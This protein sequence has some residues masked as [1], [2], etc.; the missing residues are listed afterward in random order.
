[1]GTCGALASPSWTCQSNPDSAYVDFGSLVHCKDL[2]SAH[3]GSRRLSHFQ[4]QIHDNGEYD[5]YDY[6]GDND[7]ALFASNCQPL[8]PR[9]CCGCCCIRSSDALDESTTTLIFSSPA[10]YHFWTWILLALLPLSTLLGTCTVYYS[11]DPVLS[12]D[13][14]RRALI[15][16]WVATLAILVAYVVCLP[17]RYEVHSDATLV[18]ITRLAAF[19][20]DQLVAASIDPPLIDICSYGF[21]NQ[22]RL[23][24]DVATNFENRILIRRGGGGW[25]MVVSPWNAP[26]LVAAVEQVA[27]PEPPGDEFRECEESAAASTQL[28][29]LHLV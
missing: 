28:P 1:M 20:F 7:D 11:L 19:Q 12:S 13:Q 15:G 18:V 3:A 23:R 29:R 8:L 2:N 16:L 4:A 10:S 24:W 14:R 6:D 21:Q 22:G 9:G 26:G 17:R 5:N 27:I 25:D